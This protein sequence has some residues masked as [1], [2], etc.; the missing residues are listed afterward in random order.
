MVVKRL[1][2][3]RFQ[4]IRAVS[5]KSYSKTYLMLDQSD[6]TKPKCIVK[7]LQLPTQNSVTLKFLSDLLDKRVQS[8]Q[9]LDDHPCLEKR[10]AVLQENQDFYWVRRYVPG[11]PFQMEL[12]EQ[13]ARSEAEVRKFLNEVLSILD[14][15]QQRGVVHQNLHPNNLI[16]HQIDG[17]LVLV[18]FGLVQDTHPRHY[19]PS[20]YEG[21]GKP[22]E[23]GVYLP[24]LQTPQAS[25]F[26]ADH[27]AVGV[28][29]LQLATGLSREALPL[30]DQPDFLDQ[31]RLQLDECSTLSAG[32]KNML[33]QMLVPTAETAFAQAR[34]MLT[35]L[36]R[37]T[38]PD[39]PQPLNGHHPA[40]L[41]EAESD[42]ALLNGAALQFQP[43]HTA[44]RS[45]LN[46]AAADV[47]ITSVVRDEDIPRPKPAPS[48]RSRRFWGLALGTGAT[49]VA[50][51]A[52]GWHIP[53]RL[54]TAR[55][56]QQ[57]QQAEQAGQVQAA[58]G[59]LDQLLEQHP[60]HGEALA[61]RSALLVKNGQP[62]RAL[63]DLTRALQ[64]NSK[65]PTLYFQRGNLRF[66]VGDLQG[67]I[68]DYTDALE[69]DPS[70]NQAYLNRGNARADLGDEAGAVDDYTVVLNQA[71]DPET[72]AFAYLNRCLSRSNLGDPQGALADC[73][74]AINLRPSNSLAYENRGLVKRKLEDF[75]GA[76]QDFTIAI[77]MD[78]GNPEA[79]Y[80]RGL[81]RQS[82]GDLGGAM[83][84]FNQTIKL[85]PNHPFAY[86]DRGLLYGAQGETEAA[87]ADLEK[88][89]SACLEAGRV[90]CFG[91][92]Q[93]QLKQLKAAE[94]LDP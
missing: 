66:D 10:V 33:L 34:D 69:L 36:D 45:S 1:L 37:P 59:Y 3:G 32:L 27:F 2:D 38:Q 48:R 55:L 24:P 93:Y 75:Q 77:Q 17:H 86:Y 13:S 46:G 23:N 70:Y 21:K 6:P 19:W 62:E 18:D 84:D 41:P 74:A 80:N 49:L 26:N 35:W 16:R 60:T 54:A 53:Q 5:S 73:S 42:R 78:S 79:Y 83:A 43:P 57:A 9:Q 89:A 12:S 67:A 8:L 56:A 90:G 64:Q 30:F 63:E 68:S 52:L 58:I 94:S 31:A 71:K 44:A 72:Q 29:A 14:I 85:N 28:M 61:Q 4:F 88:V 76:I 50:L 92:A 65:S 11:R 39:H 40:D 20:L 91:D 87:I 51:G 82:L 15:L 47:P 25:A 81:T 7:R 22:D